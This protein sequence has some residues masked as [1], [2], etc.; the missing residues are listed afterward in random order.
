MRNLLALI[1]RRGESAQTMIM[2]AILSSAVFMTMGLAVEGGRIFVEQR[3]MQ[4]A[5][6]MAA[7]VGAQSLPCTLNS[8]CTAASNACT[9]A[10]SNGYADHSGT[11][12]A[13]GST[14]PSGSTVSASSPPV[15]CSPY[16]FIAYGNENTAPC[17]ARNRAS[18]T[19]NVFRYIE[20]RISQP[21]TIPIPG[22]PLHIS[23]YAHA[24]ARAHPPAPIDYA[25]SVLNPTMCKAL[26]LSG[27]GGTAGGMVVVGP[28]I[29]DTNAS[30]CSSGAGNAGIYDNNASNN[31]IV[32][33]AEWL[34]TAFQAPPPSPPGKSLR[35]LVGGTP[36]IAPPACD[37]PGCTS[38]TCPAGSGTYPDATTAFE[39]GV[40]PIPDTYCL[41]FNPPTTASGQA[42]NAYDH[43]SPCTSTTTVTSMATCADCSDPTASVYTWSG[44]GKVNRQSGTWCTAAGTP[45][46]TCK[47]SQL[48]NG[49]SWELFPGVYPNGINPGGGATIFFNPGVYT[50]K[51]SMYITGSSSKADMCVFG[52]PAC[53]T[54]SDTNPVYNTSATCGDATFGNPDQASVSGPW[55]YRCSPYGV[56]DSNPCLGF[57]SGTC[58]GSVT[59]PGDVPALGSNGTNCPRPVHVTAPTFIGGGA[60]NG[61]TIPLNGVTFY[62]YSGDPGKGAMNLNGGSQYI[63]APNACPG[64]STLASGTSVPFS[65]GSVSSQYTYPSTSPIGSDGSNGVGWVASSSSNVSPLSSATYGNFSQIYPSLDFS[66]TEESLCNASFGGS[67]SLQAEPTVWSGEFGPGNAGTHLHFLE[68]GRDFAPPSTSPIATSDD[69]TNIQGNGSNMYVGIM[70]APY[71]PDPNNVSYEMSISGTAGAGT[72]PPELFGQIVTDSLQMTGNATVEVYYRPC[73]PLS[74]CSVGPGTSLVE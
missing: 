61:N 6:D 5:A 14:D 23:L 42:Q 59:C 72:G 26:E 47:T 13:N 25:I 2:F 38:A 70:Y 16:D 8:S 17:Q 64:T 66:L 74:S 65:Q 24:V 4:S 56:W 3:H 31:A 58:N 35:S 29:S 46:G 55:Y 7:L 54:F 28:V 20:V 48:F 37:S 27:A 69:Y 36:N 22:F 19:A 9:Y 15:S 30:T 39:P 43:I 41:S 33:D 12:C 68:F 50:I 11:G 21:V 62:F 57:G 18:T 67:T 73:L 34:T 71:Q 10:A 49:N 32:C 1:F 52:A 45:S 40:D 44:T 53:D 60:S 51:G 63:A